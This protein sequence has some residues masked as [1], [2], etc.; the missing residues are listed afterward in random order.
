LRPDGEPVCF[1]A[2]VQKFRRKNMGI[3]VAPT[4]GV[5]RGD[6]CRVRFGSRSNNNA[7]QVMLSH[8]RSALM[9]SLLGLRLAIFPIEDP[10]K[11][12][13]FIRCQLEIELLSTSEMGQGRL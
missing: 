3:G 13:K 6:G 11:A 2:A 4:R 7:I 12:L 5:D 1:D 10:T 9:N 8:V